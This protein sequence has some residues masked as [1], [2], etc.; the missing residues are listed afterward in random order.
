MNKKNI[1]SIYKFFLKKIKLL[2]KK[3]FKTKYVFT[4]P[5]KRSILIF[6]TKNS[7]CLYGYLDES[8][9]TSFDPL[10]IRLNI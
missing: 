4:R 9:V 6:D 3:I 1:L 2:I 10:A 7:V 5:R 8:K